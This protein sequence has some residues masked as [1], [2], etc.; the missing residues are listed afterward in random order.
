MWTLLNES[1]KI[2]RKV[3]GQVRSKE[4]TDRKWENAVQIGHCV[5]LWT[6]TELPL[7]VILNE[8]LDEHSKGTGIPELFTPV[9]DGHAADTP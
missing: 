8:V 9:H 5:T 4:A 3:T 6:S 7:C 1:P 2:P